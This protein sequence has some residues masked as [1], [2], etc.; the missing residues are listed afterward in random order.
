MLTHETTKTNNNVIIGAKLPLTPHKQSVPLLLRLS[1]FPREVED[2]G[3]GFHCKVTNDFASE[4]DRMM[5][6][7]RG[8]RRSVCVGGFWPEHDEPDCPQVQL[9]DILWGS[10]EF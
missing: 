5:V 4:S 1:V 8:R 3:C 2:R 7:Q 10:D 6:D 9:D